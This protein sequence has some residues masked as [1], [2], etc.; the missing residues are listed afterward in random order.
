M[1]KF[2]L[3][4]CYCS[5]YLAENDVLDYLLNNKVIK[6]RMINFKFSSQNYNF[7]CLLKIKL[8]SLNDVIAI[9][10]PNSAVEHLIK[11]YI[12]GTKYSVSNFFLR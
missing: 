1:K 8:I 3:L 10:S 2:H 11:I 6:T 4:V 12:Q 5:L 9:D 7:I